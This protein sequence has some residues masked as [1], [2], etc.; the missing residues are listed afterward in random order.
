MDSRVLIIGAGPAGASAAVALAQRGVTD[1]LLLDRDQFPRDKTCGSG[2]SPAALHL[3]ETLGIGERV[4]ARANPIEWV[5]LVTPGG[6]ELLLP[7]NA[8]VVIS[9]RRDF[10]QLLVDRAREL[11]VGFQP[12]FR[13][14]GLVRDGAGR[15]VGVRS[16]EGEEL[17]ASFVLCADGAH[18]IFSPDRRPKRFISTLMGWWEGSSLPQRRLDM[19]FDRNLAPLYGWMFPETATRVNIG[20]CVDGQDAQGRRAGRDLRA[21]F[22][23]FVHD[24]YREM[25]RDAHPLGKLRGHPIVFSTWVS[26][27]AAPGALWVGEAARVTHNATGEGISQAMQSGLFAAEAI[28]SV[29]HAERSE[30]AAWRHYVWQHR[31]RFTAGF[32]SGY[33]VRALVAS[34][35]LDGLARAYHSAWGQRLIE[36]LLGSA[37]TGTASQEAPAAY[38]QLAHRGLSSGRLDANSL[39]DE[40]DRS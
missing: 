17:R 40:P 15:V 3:A 26:H 28:S 27:C 37:L 6:E 23:R 4:R 10:D 21:L 31:R 7:G 38:S 2:L 14:S 11:G 39:L 29:V 25:L 30:Q 20:I 33:L 16:F 34:R 8:A 19:V 5:R 24:H 13:A 36:R 18:S 1:V 35:A 32:A 12:G 22:E 9:L